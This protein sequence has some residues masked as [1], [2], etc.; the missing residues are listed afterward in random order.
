M[1][2]SQEAENYSQLDERLQYTYGAIYLSPSIGVM[3]P[4]P[5]ANYMQTF[6]DKD[7]NHFDGGKSYRLHVP[8]D[9][10][11]SAFWSLTLYDT[12]T[13]SMVHNPTNDAARS[14]YDKLKTNTDGSLDL[15]FGPNSGGSG[16]QLDRDG[17]RPGLLHDV[18][19]VQPHRPVVRWH[20]D[21]AG[22]RANVTPH[23][24]D[25]RGRTKWARQVLAPPES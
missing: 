2:P 3:K 24:S 15:Y 13:R 18:P 23:R 8:A 21:T 19:P 7:G 25:R 5:G 9:P 1:K 4:G 14:G 10:P 20:V 16:E 6:R 17:S 11:A 22:R 12:A